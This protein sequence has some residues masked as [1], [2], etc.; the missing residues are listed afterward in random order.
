MSANFIVTTKLCIHPEPETLSLNDLDSVNDATATL[1][2]AP[3]AVVSSE[4]VAD[5]SEI[6]VMARVAVDEMTWGV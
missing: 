1:T 6:P 2:V 3:T 4:P 5:S